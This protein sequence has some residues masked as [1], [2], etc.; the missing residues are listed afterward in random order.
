MSESYKTA[1]YDALTP[2]E[3]YE[4]AEKSVRRFAARVAFY[5]E[6]AN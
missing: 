3:Y 1:F 5:R 4:R 2:A 6:S